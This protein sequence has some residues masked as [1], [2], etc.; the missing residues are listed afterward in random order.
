MAI[1]STRRSTTIVALNA[2]S[3]L[4]HLAQ[5]G[6][7]YPLLG[8]WLLH[9]GAPAWRIGLIVT[10]VWPGMLAAS[11]VS[12]QIV[13]HWGPAVT[14]TIGCLGSACVALGLSRLGADAWPAWTLGAAALGAFTGLRWVGVESWLYAILPGECKGR[15]LSL[16]E[17]VIYAAQGLGPALIGVVGLGGPAVFYLAAGLAA[18]AVVPLCAGSF[19]LRPPPAPSSAIDAPPMR[20]ALASAAHQGSVRIAVLAGVIDGMLLGMLGVYLGRLGH[21]GAQV[22]ALLTAFGVGG[23]LSQWPVGW[24]CDRFGLASATRAMALLGGAGMLL[25]LTDASLALWLGVALLG[26][27]SACVLTLA[28]IAAI[29]EAR[30]GAVDMP[31]AVARVTAAFTVGGS[32]GPAMAGGLM[33]GWGNTAFAAA[34]LISCLLLYWSSQ[35]ERSIAAE[36]QDRQ[37]EAGVQ[38]PRPVHVRPHSPDQATVDPKQ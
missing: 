20:G 7:L 1:E 30:S 25:V 34:T 6:L 36:A 3:G 10:A 35:R 33:D 24:M 14:T 13:R 5:F 12:S 21:S 8:L 26:A 18:L 17:T 15:L 27:L 11:L 4:A 29:D 38:T 16:H 23:V 22:A 28:S 32:L 9:K 19:R 31:G 2:V 37:A